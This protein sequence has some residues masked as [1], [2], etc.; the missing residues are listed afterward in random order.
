MPARRVLV[1]LLVLA[2]AG[3]IWLWPT[4]EGPVLDVPR[5]ALACARN[6]R[7]VYDGLQIYRARSG[8]PPSD[9]GGGF[10]RAVL[11]DDVWADTPENRSKLLCPGSGR[12]YA[13][14][15]TTAYPLARFPS[16]G[17]E[18][19]PLASCDGGDRPAHEGCMNV[20]YSDG[21]VLTLILAEEIERGRLAPGTTTI[22]L[23]P[24]SPIPE[25]RK[26]VTQRP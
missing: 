18:L 11:A 25:L 26:L 5:D 23:G 10:L 19:E 20:L 12:P 2:L 24:D 14:R 3:A 7:Q 21:S 9:S 13:A 15:D 1:P 8:H 16:G 22:A 4:G 17:A 6:L